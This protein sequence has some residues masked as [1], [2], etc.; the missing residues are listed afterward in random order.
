MLFGPLAPSVAHRDVDVVVVAQGWVAVARVRWVPVSVPAAGPG[1][2]AAIED[3]VLD[4][5]GAGVGDRPLRD[6]PAEDPSLWVR[7]GD[8]RADSSPMG[9][10]A[11]LDRP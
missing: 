6:P 11:S 8:H 7:V 5:E 4:V 2:D 3:H 9:V 10:V 1:P